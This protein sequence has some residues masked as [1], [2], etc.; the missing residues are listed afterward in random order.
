MVSVAG[1]DFLSEMNISINEL[2]HTTQRIRS[3]NGKPLKVLG[4]LYVKLQVKDGNNIPHE[5]YDVIYIIENAPAMFLSL[6]TC[7]ALGI[8]PASFPLPAS[9]PEREAQ[10]I[11][12][13]PVN[14]G[15]TSP[16]EAGV[17]RTPPP[18]RPSALPFLAT[19]EHIDDLKKWLLDAFASSAFNTSSY[20]LPAMS[21]PPMKIHIKPDAQPHAV[22][23]PIPISHHWKQQVKADL[24]RDVAMGIIEPVPIGTPTTFCAKMLTVPKKSGQPRRVVDLQALNKHCLR[25]THHTSSPFNLAQTIPSGTYKTVLDAWNGYHAIALDEDSKNLTQFVTEFGRYRYCR[26]PQG[27]LAS[28][29]AYTRRFDA[30]TQDVPRKAKCVDDTLLWDDSIADSFWHTFDYLSLCST[31]GITFNA[32]KFVFAQKSLDFAGLQIT[33]DHI[34]PS[35]QMLASIRD[36]PTP[37]NITGA[38]AWFGLC[39]QVAW[40]YAIKPEMQPLRDLVKPSTPFYWDEQLNNVFEASKQHILSLVEDG[41]R[42]FEVN[43][44]TCL[45]TDYSKYGIGFVLLQKYCLCPIESAPTCCKTGWKLVFA[46]SRF[47]TPTEEGYQAIEGEALAVASSLHKCR[48]FVLGCPKLIVAVDHRPLVGIFNSKAMEKIDNPRLFRLKE[49]TLLFR[50]TAQYSAG[51]WHKAPDCMSRYPTQEASSS[52]IDSIILDAAISALTSEN[53][54]ISWEELSAMCKTDEHYKHLTQTVIEGFPTDKAN[55][56]S[57]LLPYWRVRD[58]L[59]VIDGVCL[60]DSR[61]VIPIALRARVMASLHSAHQ[62]HSGMRARAR[63]SVYWPGMDKSLRNYLDTCHYCRLHAPSQPREP[64]T[65]AAPSAW[66]YEC[67]VADHFDVKGKSY[68]VIA[69]RYSGNMHIFRCPS[70]KP[71]AQHLVSTSRDL[72]N[73]Y[74]VPREF[75][76]DGGTSFTS[77]EFQSFLNYW[78]IKHRLSSAYFPQSNG[79]AELAVKMAKRIIANCTHPSGTLDTDAA[80]K[81]IMQY[82][83]TPLTTVGKSPS[84][85][86]FGRILRDHIPAATTQYEPHPEWLIKKEERHAATTLRDQYIKKRYDLSSRPLKPLH[87]GQR[88]IVQNQGTNHPRLWEHS[89]TVIEVLPFRRYKIVLDDSQNTTMRNRRFLRPLQATRSG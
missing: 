41:V 3:V 12:V 16:P 81:A 77:H 21:G 15:A 31:N 72:F 39:E 59:S 37:K 9:K 88:V 4:Y 70:G 22:H 27:Y 43:R 25:E 51:K 85:I 36:F 33:D 42:T 7:K 79:R 53:D 54:P 13:S 69:D 80:S 14:S 74:G 66:P 18:P 86:L 61:P 46:G 58:H 50:F 23:T 55:I 75:A 20:P 52:D 76:S 5:T 30:I 17:A 49:K 60:F 87:V 10:S 38:R 83:N 82:R 40:A 6:S 65:P 71:S 62:G 63:I 64:Y 45:A 19:P 78:G 32:D 68:L 29:D 35:S 28:G 34:K 57:H 24:D 8:I 73:Q 56:P 47:T 67:V 11:T 44:P 1:P 89:G 26:A 2:L 84:Q 48:M